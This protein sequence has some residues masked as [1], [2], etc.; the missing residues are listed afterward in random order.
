MTQPFTCFNYLQLFVTP[1]VLADSIADVAINTTL[2]LF[3]FMDR[4][5]PLAVSTL[6]PKVPFP[7]LYRAGPLAADVLPQLNP[8]GL[9]LKA[10]RDKA[11]TKQP[12]QDALVDML[13]KQQ[14]PVIVLAT[15]GRWQVHLIKTTYPSQ[16][17]VGADVVLCIN[18]VLGQVW[19]LNAHTQ[20]HLL[21]PV[22]RPHARASRGQALAYHAPHGAMCIYVL[23]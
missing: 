1:A 3:H 6:K 16:H 15:G 10:L 21:R 18:G 17:S 2:K 22:W 19:S 11:L 14:E 8:A 4:T 12:G 9:N 5:V 13:L 20:Q 23:G 7:M